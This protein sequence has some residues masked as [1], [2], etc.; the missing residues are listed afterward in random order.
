VLKIIARTTKNKGA[1]R[2][3]GGLGHV[4]KVG[5]VVILRLKSLESRGLQA[6]LRGDLDPIRLFG[7]KLAPFVTN[8]R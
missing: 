5:V 7:T 1:S 6:P 8:K 3:K 4:S 2:F